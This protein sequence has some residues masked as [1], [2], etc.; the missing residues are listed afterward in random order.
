MPFAWSQAGA[1]KGKDDGGGWRVEFGTGITFSSHRVNFLLSLVAWVMETQRKLSHSKCLILNIFGWLLLPDVSGS[2]LCICL[3]TQFGPHLCS[4][5]QAQSTSQPPACCPN[6]WPTRCRTFFWY[7]LEQL[8]GCRHLCQ[9][10]VFPRGCLPHLAHGD[11]KMPSD[12]SLLSWHLHRDGSKQHP[13]ASQHGTG[14]SSA[15]SS[16][17]S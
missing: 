17:A 8:R 13:S 10:S 14:N 1:Q 9:R 4:R 6:C 3:I 5:L 2:S 7:L 15:P 12:S 11:A 16:A